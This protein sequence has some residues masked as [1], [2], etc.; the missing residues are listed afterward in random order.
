MTEM[1]SVKV[2]SKFQIAVPSEARRRL[3]IVAGDRLTV[4]IENDELVLRRRPA[5]ASQRLWGLGKGLYGPDPVAFVRS[6]RD[7]LETNLDERKAVV[8]R[9]HDQVPSPDRD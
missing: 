6:L 5:K 7:E 1:L 4:T 9:E 8:D 3:G 2:S